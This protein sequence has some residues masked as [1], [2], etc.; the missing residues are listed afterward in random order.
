MEWLVLTAVQAVSSIRPPPLTH[1]ISVSAHQ[2]LPCS[3][4]GNSYSKAE[5][6]FLLSCGA[7]GAQT[8]VKPESLRTLVGADESHSCFSEVG[9]GVVY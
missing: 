4:Y 3:C 1:P 8:M 5:S 9:R 7:F 2:T 6:R